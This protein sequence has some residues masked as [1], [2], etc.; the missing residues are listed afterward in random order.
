MGDWQRSYPRFSQCGLNCGLCPRYHTDGASRCPGCGGADFFS[1]RPACG[2]ISCARKK[3]VAEYCYLCEEYPCK[4][5]NGVAL[6]DSFITHQNMM[7]DFEKAKA[8]G[9][10]AYQAEL[11]EKVAALEDLLAHYNDGRRKSFFCTAVNLLALQDVRAVMAQ[12]EQTALAGDTKARAACAVQLFEGM[13]AQRGIT[14][15]LNKKKA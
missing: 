3:G 11:D 9:M 5:Y 6:H 10:E 1:K 7:T 14:L 13:A 2:V 15:K 12:L 4:K 8:V